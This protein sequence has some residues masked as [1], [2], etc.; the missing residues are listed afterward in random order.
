MSDKQVRLQRRL[1]ALTALTPCRTLGRSTRLLNL[2][3][4]RGPTFSKQ[5]RRTQLQQASGSA[6]TRA[7]RCQSWS[8]EFRIVAATRDAGNDEP[9]ANSCHCH[10]WRSTAK[11]ERVAVPLRTPTTNGSRNRTWLWLRASARSSRKKCSAARTS[12]CFAATSQERLSGAAAERS[13]A[14]RCFSKLAPNAKGFD[15]SRRCLRV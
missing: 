4:D 3:S 6:D 11:A 8:H 12:W 2:A 7:R 15:L 9:N 5:N 13:G 10:G 1:D 14:Q